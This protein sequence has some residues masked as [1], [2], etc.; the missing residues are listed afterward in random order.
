MATSE[1]QKL[2]TPKATADLLGVSE[3]TLRVW[4][5]TKRY[6]LSYVKIGSSVRYRMADIEAFISDRMERPQQATA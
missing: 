5:T 1:D 2:L 4:R 3:G 6:P